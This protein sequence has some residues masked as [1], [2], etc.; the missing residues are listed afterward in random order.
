MRNDDRLELVHHLFATVAQERAD[1]T[2]LVAGSV[3]LTYGEL[4]ARAFRLAHRLRAAGAGPDAP[5]AVVADKGGA[6]WIVA[7]L[8]VWAS[9]A[10]YLPI[11]PDTPAGRVEPMIRGAAPVAVVGPP[12]PWDG[13]VPHRLPA[14]AGDELPL[15]GSP[16]APASSM[17]AVEMSA[18]RLAYII[19]TSGS[20]GE[21]KPVSVPHRALA[22][23][24]RAWEECYELTPEPR[25]V[26]QGA[27]AAFD[28]HVGDIARALLS[29]GRLV[30]CP[31]HVLLDPP[32][33]HALIER[34]SIDLMELTPSVWR[35]LVSW[36]EKTGQ[37]LPSVRLAISGGEQWTAAE[38][39]RLRGVT[40][41]LTRIVNS[42]GVAE[43]AVDSTWHEVTDDTLDGDLVPIGKPFPGVTALVLGEDLA[44][45]PPGLP[46]EL[47]LAGDGLARE[48]LGRPAA[49]AERFVP[50]TGG[51]AGQRMYRTGDLVR[52]RSDGVLTHLGRLDDEVK[53]RGVRFQLG[54]VEAV[55]A[56]H[57]Q[58]RAVAVARASRGDHHML[59]A[60]V[61][62]TSPAA[63]LA[64]RIRRFAAR[65]L[66]SAMVPAEVVI[67]SSLWL[68]PA[69]KLD[70][71]ALPSTPV[72]GVPAPD[73]PVQAASAQDMPDGYHGIGV[74]PGT[75]PAGRTATEEVVIR[76]WTE[77]LGSPPASL[78][79]DFFQAGGD[80]LAAAWLALTLRN[81]CGADASAAAVYGAPTVVELARHLDGLPP[82]EPVTSASGHRPSPHQRRLWTVH[83]LNPGDPSYNLPTLLRL[84][85][86]L[87]EDVLRQAL[88]LLVAR[89]DALRTRFADGADELETHVET[90]VT[91]PLDV[92][93]APESG[94][95]PV[96]AAVLRPFDLG[97]A[98]LCRATL[99]RRGPDE[100]DLVFVAH[101][102]V[103]DGWSERI[104]VRELG[105]IYSAL[106]SGARPVPEPVRRSYA[107]FA[108]WQNRRLQDGH[109][110]AARDYWRS[111]L[112]SPP[113]LLDLPE[114]PQRSR[115]GLAG[116][117]TRDLGAD[118]SD[119]VRAVARAHGATPYAA[120][121]AALAALLSRWS[122][123][124]DLVIGGP[125][126]DRD[127]PENAHLVGF[128]VSTL[129]LR[130][131]VP[132]EAAFS[133]VLRA[134][135]RTVAEAI[136]H[137][138]VPF[139]QIVADLGLAGGGGR[140]P[141]FR[142][143]LNLLGRSVEPP[144]MAGLEVEVA[145]PPLPGALFDL[146][147]Y[148]T[149][150]ADGYRL[151]AVYDQGRLDSAHVAELLEQLSLLLAAACASPETPLAAH[152]LRTGPAAEIL[153]K[154]TADLRED[155]PELLPELW[156]RGRE[157]PSAPAVRDRDGVL[158]F[159]DL[160]AA[161]A[162]WTR[163]LTA[164]GTGEDQVVAV[165]GA[166][167]AGLVPALLGI[168]ATG[169]RFT[170][171]DSDHPRSRLA[172]Q[173]AAAGVR[174]GAELTGTP[175]AALPGPD[176]RW[177]A[178]PDAAA[179]K[180]TDPGPDGPGTPLP[181]TAAYVAFTSGT[182][183]AP[184]GISA[185]TRPLAHF[186]DWY[187]RR[188][189]LGRH[190]RFALVS[191]IAHDP[192]LRDILAPLWAGA[193]L[194]VPPT[195]LMRDPAALRGWLRDEGVTV[196]HVTPAL[197]RMLALPERAPVPE[198]VRLVC[199]AGD[200]LS[201]RD[202][203]DIASWAPSAQIVNGYGATET[204]QLA[205][206]YDVRSGDAALERVPVGSGI[207]GF[208]LLVL[209]PG[210]R[211]AGIGERGEIVVRS[212]YLALGYL[213]EE[214]GFHAD[215]VP[216]HRRFATG[217]LGRYGPDGLV[218]VLGRSDDQVK[219]RG[220][221]V[222]LGEVDVRLRECPGV[223]D[224]AGA[225]RVG[226]DGESRIVAY[227]VPDASQPVSD[228]RERLRR[229]LPDHM[230]P[231]SVVAV[232]RIPLT[233]N[234][235]VDRAA[236][237]VAPRLPQPGR[238]QEVATGLERLVASIWQGVLGAE[239]VPLHQNFFDLG[240]DSMS[241][242]RAHVAL[243]RE[244]GRKIP[245]TALFAHPNVHHLAAFLASGE[246][247]LDDVTRSRAELG[248]LRARRL[249]ARDTAVS[250]KGRA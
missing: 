97:A 223:K 212:P 232:E 167:V 69:G 128:C 25:A 187:V 243:E 6:D 233:L 115:A 146:G 204:P 129:P 189:R 201:G 47:F 107:D 42:Y 64:E 164:T 198:R 226:A 30:L 32:A 247:A 213:R 52:L 16:N 173:L 126:G 241:M 151:E 7:V 211:P 62:P 27:G 50:L 78:E 186:L 92:I 106:A 56:R 134:A 24:Y 89:H 152:D 51:G 103:F 250:K 205:G 238:S 143:W 184:R 66:P 36:L 104:L 185:D 118:L 246:V 166:R 180:I 131:A 76:A 156:R 87:R 91:V 231:S 112:A 90:D 86:R 230:L 154:G 113:A 44:P 49:T 102:V 71:R 202:L 183:G 169:A 215:P 225:V 8:G 214:G 181:D 57:P 196:L 29:G 150:R 13:L 85:G 73:E 101:H 174:L 203:L 105:E 218:T 219:V 10:A 60:H 207:P 82:A 120:L 114:P 182:T 31:T 4:A 53:V 178:T 75:A 121:L 35:L 58:V 39:R 19:H 136:A 21:P 2:A 158:T 197:C 235:K 45:V 227:V 191:G 1:Q 95:D 148:V 26:L 206:A 127:R 248:G 125:F 55:L 116:R 83:R 172:E 161:A 108:A 63:G 210:G 67:T 40:G 12:G 140:N 88:D 65:E 79:E 18:D 61:V 221:R 168:L 28:V 111:T 142:V 117:T 240:A 70:R 222:E 239:H 160:Y 124:D 84:R 194:C 94:P 34:E 68:T 138:D 43:A 123:Q 228:V 193:T 80:S 170:V 149:D 199:C 122:G 171:L 163:T 188:Y 224:A 20:T 5:V 209:R 99:V 229:T 216:E 159:A 132:A 37:S 177:I 41:Q 77:V 14:S 236:L 176:V 23:V 133:E 162:A 100:H 157:Q 119:Q 153:P 17:P 144:S 48:Y 130:M 72:Q 155:V 165:H 109:G 59:V 137:A 190:D 33:L 244:L 46:G 237:A 22:C 98:P 54:S 11:D 249:A 220:H 208:E 110:Q 38:Y 81:A 3:T 179:R 192:L 234:G 141:L 93:E 147:I 145:E 217:D 135:R 9:G 195:E 175:A 242:I 245:P 96:E 200:S 139:D 15:P 74:R